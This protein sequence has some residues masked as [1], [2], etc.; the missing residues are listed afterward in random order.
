MKRVVAHGDLDPDIEEPPHR[1]HSASQPIP[2][3]VADAA[4]LCGVRDWT[5]RVEQRAEK[6]SRGWSYSHDWWCFE[7]EHKEQGAR[8]ELFHG[9]CVDIAKQ[10]VQAGVL[11]GPRQAARKM[12][13]D[14]AFAATWGYVVS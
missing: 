2:Q 9:C 11:P 4:T 6:T 5:C 3:C 1:R 14:V 13:D 10:A 7:R 12:S 8:E